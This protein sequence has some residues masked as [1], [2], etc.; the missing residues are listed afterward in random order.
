MS[1]C[2]SAAVCALVG[3]TSVPLAEAEIISVTVNT[4]RDYENAQHYTY[5]EV[6]IH[7][8]VA[9]ADGSAGQYIVPAVV[10]YPRD[11]RN[12]IGVVDWLNCAFYHF[13]SPS[14]EF[15]TCNSR[16]SRR[17]TTYSK[18]DKHTQRFSGTRR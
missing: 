7:G 6:T 5:A 8:S 14:T 1:L 11:G 4:T 17:G 2:L 3:F 16:V 9:R 13:F 15:G 12:G 10:I 18:K